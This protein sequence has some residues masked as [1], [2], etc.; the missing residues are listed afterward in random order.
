MYPRDCDSE[1]LLTYQQRQGLEELAVLD[2]NV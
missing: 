1:P 2:T